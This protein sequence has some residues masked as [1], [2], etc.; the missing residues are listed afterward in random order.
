[1]RF[2]V[3]RF[4]CLARLLRPAILCGAVAGMVAVGCTAR[5]SGQLAALERIECPEKPPTFYG[6]VGVSGSERSDALTADRKEALR[7]GLTEVAVCAGR[8]R[9]VLFS[10]SAAAT[11]VIF[12]GE[13]VPGGATKNARL[14]RVAGLV[15][16]AMAGI[17]QR[18]N[19]DLQALPAEASDPMAQLTLAAEYRRQVGLA[20]PFKVL[21]LSDG[22][23]TTNVVLNTPQLDSATAEDLGRRVSVPNLGAGTRLIFAGIGRVAG[24]PP[25]TSFVD[26]LKGFFRRACERTGAKCSVV[27][28]YVADGGWSS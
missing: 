18:W 28:D 3:T 25:P 1:M 11:T 24:P 12:E 20:R 14:R 10:S 22:L 27:S 15:D 5:P 9:V 17:E 2:L 7:A 16:E 26:A 19:I 4:I 21:I 8:A 23:S 13:L 6:A